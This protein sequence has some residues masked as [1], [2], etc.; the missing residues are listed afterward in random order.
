[1]T[2]EY[3]L[4]IIFIQKKC[5]FRCVHYFQDHLAAETHTTA[6]DGPPKRLNLGNKLLVEWRSF[7]RLF[8]ITCF[9]ATHTLN[10]LD[11]KW[12]TSTRTRFSFF[13]P[14]LDVIC[15]QPVRHQPPGKPYKIG[16][17][18][19]AAFLFASSRKEI[20]TQQDLNHVNMSMMEKRVPGESGLFLSQSRKEGEEKRTVL[21]SR[22]DKAPCSHNAPRVYVLHYLL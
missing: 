22:V 13:R 8:I 3:L 21:S 17:F 2:A 18:N 14:H 1:V 19:T 4:Y 11:S 16:G 5:C 6:Q 15:N 7:I 10:R 12:P 9:S 20:K